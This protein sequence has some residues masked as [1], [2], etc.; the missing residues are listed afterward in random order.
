MPTHLEV[1]SGTGKGFERLGE[2]GGVS[3]FANI[4]LDGRVGTIVVCPR[5]TSDSS[6]TVIGLPF[7]LERKFTLQ[8]LGEPWFRVIGTKVTLN[9]GQHLLI[10]SLS[11][12]GDLIKTFRIF[13]E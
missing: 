12:S 11:P 8:D 9:S 3:Q 1:N 4:N 7:I 10:P 13:Q 2:I 5:L 6:V